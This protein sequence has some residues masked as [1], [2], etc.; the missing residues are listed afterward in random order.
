MVKIYLADGTLLVDWFDTIQKL[1]DDYNLPYNIWRSFYSK[2][3]PYK[4]TKKN[5]LY[6]HN[7]YADIVDWKVTLLA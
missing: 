7:S 3:L 2:G 6:L 4:T 1:I 5:L